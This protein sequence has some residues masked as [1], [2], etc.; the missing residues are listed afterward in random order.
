MGTVFSILSMSRCPCIHVE[1]LR[2]KTFFLLRLFS[3]VI[4]SGIRIGWGA[5]T[6]V[7]YVLPV[8]RRKIL[9]KLRYHAT[10]EPA[11]RRLLRSSECKRK[12]RLL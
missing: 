7:K 8:V 12:G 9:R 1:C 5:Q 3:R 11:K 10:W 4:A 6:N 2:N